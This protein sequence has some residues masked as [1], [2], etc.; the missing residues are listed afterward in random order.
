MY[1]IKARREELGLLQSDIANALDV[2]VPTVSRWESGDIK[3]MKRDKIAQLA[4]I[5]EISPVDLIL[6]SPPNAPAALFVTTIDEIDLINKYRKLTKE[7]KEQA[8]QFIEF[9]GK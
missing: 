6:D 5:L 1:D 2:T 7:Q 4:K 9:I 8:K 3:N